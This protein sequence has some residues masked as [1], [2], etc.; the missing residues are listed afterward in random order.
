MKPWTPDDCANATVLLDSEQRGIERALARS[1]G[2]RRAP[3]PAFGSLVG[4][5]LSL[6]FV[7][8][9]AWALSPDSPVAREVRR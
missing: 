9:L 3:R 7:A 1:P 5:G 2:R 8:G 6:L 4:L